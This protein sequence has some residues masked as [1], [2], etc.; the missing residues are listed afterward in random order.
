M[1]KICFFVVVF[2]FV[3]KYSNNEVCSK[4]EDKKTLSKCSYEFY[5]E[6]KLIVKF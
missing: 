5:R 6:F 1:F 3:S 4:T 2:I